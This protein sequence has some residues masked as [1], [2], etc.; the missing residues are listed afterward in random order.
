M[1]Y[2]G[3]PPL[4]NSDR[5]VVSVS[6]EF[7]SNSQRDARF[8]CKAYDY[9]RADWDGLRDHVRAVPWEDIFILLLVLANFV[10]RFGLELMYISLIAN[11]RSSHTHLHGF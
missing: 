4:R 3:V 7:Q 11:I 9:S 2:N 1:F 10:N 6:I 8:H 5:T